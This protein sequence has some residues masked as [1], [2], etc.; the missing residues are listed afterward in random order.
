MTNSFQIVIDV[1]W[2][3]NHLMFNV[4]VSNLTFSPCGILYLLFPSIRWWKGFL[5]LFTENAMIQSM[6]PRTPS[7]AIIRRSIPS[8]TKPKLLLGSSSVFSDNTIWVLFKSFFTSSRKSIL[9]WNWLY[10]I[11]ITYYTYFLFLDKNT[12]RSLRAPV[13]LTKDWEDGLI[14]STLC[15]YGRWMVLCRAAQLREI[16]LH[17]KV[18]YKPTN[19][20]RIYWINK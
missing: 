2:L 3:N 1:V 9:I 8:T 16:K 19:Y 5:F 18:W 13:R 11:I 14:S 7:R 4:R 20:F 17:R 6:F 10:F 15:R 12:A